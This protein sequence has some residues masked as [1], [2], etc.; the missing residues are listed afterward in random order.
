[1]K[2]LSTI[3]ETHPAFAR[4]LELEII[5]VVITILSGLVNYIQTG[6]IFDTNV[7]ILAL[8]APITAALLK[9]QRDLEKDNP[10][11]NSTNETSV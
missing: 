3:A 9:R 6:V 10:A 5:S 4:F 7:I 1:M 11:N 8:L 2:F